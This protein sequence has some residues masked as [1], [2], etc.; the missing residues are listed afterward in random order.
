MQWTG[1]T[2]DV[3]AELA[4]MDLFVLP[5]LFGEGMPMVLLEAMA[6]GLPVVATAVEGI[7]EA[8]RHGRD[9]LICQPADPH[10]LAAAI[11]RII[12][13]EVDY[14]ELAQSALRRHA[15]KFS[16][17]SMAAGVAEVYRRVLGN[18]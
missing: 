12:S 10:G 1:F 4:R 3:D 16:E 18:A 13:G 5:S 11:E 2:Q 9:G 7:P 17:A 6:A 8:I 14:R 15:E